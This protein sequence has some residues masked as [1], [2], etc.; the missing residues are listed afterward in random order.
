MYILYMNSINCEICGGCYKKYFH[1]KHLQ[2]NK[3]RQAAMDHL[4][5]NGDVEKYNLMKQVE[6]LQEALMEQRV[7]NRIL[8]GA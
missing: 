7:M 4:E 8:M 3:H 6:L 1:K 2:T 5:A